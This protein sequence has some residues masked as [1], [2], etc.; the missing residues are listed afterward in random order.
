MLL[1][2]GHSF[3]IQMLNKLPNFIKLR[4]IIKLVP[5]VVAP[6]TEIGRNYEHAVGPVEVFGQN[7]PIKIKIVD[8]PNRNWHQSKILVKLSFYKWQLQF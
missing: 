1:D 4:I 6:V 2:A 8:L 3:S 5:E 7:F